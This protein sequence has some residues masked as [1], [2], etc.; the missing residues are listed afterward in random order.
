TN[1]VVWTV[2]DT[3][4]NNASCTQQV[5]VVAVPVDD[6]NFSIL[7]IE[8]T[9]NDINLTWQT[10]GNSSNVVQT[11][12]PIVGG[13]YTNS[14]IDIATLVVPGNGPVTTN[15]VDGGGATNVPSRYYRILFQP[16]PACSP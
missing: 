1:L 7:G 8:A 11:V 12:A 4:A 15:Y 16:G 6:S 13:N 2:T 3:S 10:F 14:Y 5:I 9:G